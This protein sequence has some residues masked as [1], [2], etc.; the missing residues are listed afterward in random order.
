MKKR[1]S[2]ARVTSASSAVGTAEVGAVHR[3]AGA[4]YSNTGDA[5]NIAGASAVK[6]TASAVH[7]PRALLLDPSFPIG[8]PIK[9]DYSWRR[10]PTELAH[11]EVPQPR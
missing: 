8:R 10:R 11:Q 9:N 6:L 3:I 7:S 1:T 2:R 4:V 5:I